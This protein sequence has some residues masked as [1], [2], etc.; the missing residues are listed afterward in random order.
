MPLQTPSRGLAPLPG[1]IKLPHSGEALRSA[2]VPSA[3]PAGGQHA[4]APGVI[5]GPKG[6]LR[7]S[8]PIGDVRLDISKATRGMARSD[9][10]AAGRNGHRPTVW[11]TGEL[12]P[13]S[14]SNKD[15]VTNSGA[16]SG[17]IQG[18]AGASAVASTNANANGGGA[19]SSSI[20]TSPGNSGGVVT[21]QGN[22]NVGT[23]GN[24]KGNNGNGIGNGGNTG[25]NGNNGNGRGGNNGN[26][27][28]NSGGNNGKGHNG[29][30]G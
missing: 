19:G 29:R 6:A 18:S 24:G 20:S 11:S 14:P 26:G 3:R 21:A 7:I 23:G 15:A 25:N 8:A 5:G 16:I 13:G 2:S 28:G 30:G 9:A 4:A 22:G 27:N 12:N 10:Q 1:A 17:A